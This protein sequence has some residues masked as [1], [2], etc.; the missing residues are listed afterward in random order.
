MTVYPI[1]HFTGEDITRMDHLRDRLEDEEW[2]EVLNGWSGADWCLSCL[3]HGTV[4][5]TGV[6]RGVAGSGQVSF[7]VHQFRCTKCGHEFGRKQ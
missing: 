3:S 2:E 7:P 4:K 6:E 1:A 5:M